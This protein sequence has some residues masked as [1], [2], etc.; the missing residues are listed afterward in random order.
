MTAEGVL[1]IDSREHRTQGRNR[2]A[3]R[4]RLVTLIRRASVAPARR[5]PTKSTRGATERRLATKTRR[6]AVK[7]GRSRPSGDD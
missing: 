2:E 1:V 3:A 7:A 6:A 4:V 5:T